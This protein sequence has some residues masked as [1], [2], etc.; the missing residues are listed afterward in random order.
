MP[1][2]ATRFPGLRLTHPIIVVLAAAAALL[3]RPAL[4]QEEAYRPGGKPKPAPTQPE[5]KAPK[6][7]PK[8]LKD[9]AREV[10]GGK[11]GSKAAAGGEPA[12]GGRWSIVL[13]AFRE[14]DQDAKARETLD[15]IKTRGGLSEAYLEKRGAATV[16]AYGD[17]A[18]PGSKEAKADLERIHNLTVTVDGNAQKPYGRAFFAPP[19]GTP[20]NTPEYDL[21]NAKRLNGNWVLYTLQIGVYTRDD[22]KPPS[23]KELAEFRKTAEDAVVKLRREGEQAYYYHGPTAS[24]V[25]IGLF[26]KEDFDPQVP[27]VQSPTLTALRQRFPYNLLNGMGIRNR[28]TLTDPKTGKKIKQERIQPSG[29]V[30]VPAEVKT[31]K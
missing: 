20:G 7:K 17:Y 8:D 2:S 31:G 10:L 11:G 1:Q 13:E 28:V 23:E 24:L 21:V 14:G 27:G 9:E 25:T 30:A 6:D 29:L 22:N 26:G 4:A 3:G 19:E 15:Q 18:D 5:K 16:I 12:A